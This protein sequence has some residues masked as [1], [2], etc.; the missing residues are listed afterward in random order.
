MR[1]TVPAHIEIRFIRAADAG[2][3]A[4][5]AALAPVAAEPEAGGLAALDAGAD[6][7]GEPDGD[8]EEDGARPDWLAAGPRFSALS[9]DFLQPEAKATSKLARASSA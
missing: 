1:V 2:C 4:A 5:P 8:E 6:E 3:A 9:D 7:L